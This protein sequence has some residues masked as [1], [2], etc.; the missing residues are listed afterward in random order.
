MSVREEVEEMIRSTK[1][2]IVEA[3]DEKIRCIENRK[4][5]DIVIDGMGNKNTND[6]EDEAV[7]MH[8]EHIIDMAKVRIKALEDVLGIMDS[9]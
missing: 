9:N 1:Q 5:P 7:L 8:C 4:K 6:R 2:V 3:Q